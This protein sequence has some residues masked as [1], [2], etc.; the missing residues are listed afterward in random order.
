MR[1]RIS[2]RLVISTFV[3]GLA[4]AIAMPASAQTT[5]GTGQADTP[6]GDQP[7]E[8]SSGG[9]M[10]EIIV[11]AQKRRESSQKVGIAITAVSGEQIKTMGVADSV[12]IARLSSNVS[13][14][15]SYAGQ[16][17][18][19]T[20][21]GITQNDFNDHVESVIAVY[22]DDTYVA[23]QQGQ[24]FGLFDI[25]RVE[26]LKGPQGT[27][28]GRNATGGLVHYITRRPTDDFNGYAD[29]SYGSYNDVRL[30]GALG[31]RIAQG[32]R[33]RLS[34]MFERFDGYIK[35]HYPEETFV[36]IALQ[37]AL[38]SSKLPGAGADLGGMKSNW[39]LRG[40]LEF[41]LGPDTQLWMAGFGSHSVASTG[42]Y[43]Q[44]PTVAVLDAA[45]NHVNTLHA[46][47]TEVCQVIQVGACVHGGFSSYPGALRPRPGG[48]W[49]G[50]IDPDG[51]GPITSSDYTFDNANTMTTYG[52]S[53]KL[54]SSV[55]SV[56][57][58]LI[59]DYKEFKKNF[60]LDLEAGP[61]N[62]F[63]W[64]GIANTKAFTQELRVDGTSGPLKWVTGLYYLNIKTHA[65]HGI[66]A[67]PDS[68]YPIPSWDQPRIANLKTESYSAFGQLDYQLTDTVNVI[69]GLRWTREKKRYDFEV[70]FVYPND[71]GDPYGWDYSPA[72]DFPGFSQGLYA[73][74]RSETLWS[75]KGGINWQP[76]RD[77]LVYASVT[78][79]AKAGSYNAGGPPLAASEIPYKPERLISYEVG[80][81]STLFGGKARFNAA[82]YYYDYHN[83]QA[84]RWLG[85]SSLITNADATIYGGE[86]ELAASLTHNLEASFNIG[87]QHNTVKDVLV[88]GVRRNVETTF[89]PKLTLS[90]TIRYTVPT[91]IAGGEV[92]IQASA[93]YQSRVWHNL[94]NFDANS[95][96]PYGLV[97]ARID[98]TSADKNWLVAFSVKNL[99][100]N[101]YD[102]IG[103]DLSQVCG[104]NLQAQGKPRWFSVSVRRSF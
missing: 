45:G 96:A 24:T 43:Q 19:F 75:W 55:G 26:A 61:E 63:A 40:Q 94:N 71:N 80:L 54:T 41:D 60:N 102:N 30:E 39:A 76:N 100:N 29:V 42:P 57:V 85:F 25:D 70:L 51:S 87:A 1:S 90:G 82:G 23:S 18:Q 37:P 53:A 17:S 3:S 97:N 74:S 5:G 62:Q 36:P 20:I 4:L 2:K 59:S 49:F 101:V 15:G 12:D 14:S 21:R 7:S 22:I 66:A 38:H 50:Y 72:I 27:L 92:G 88:G 78:Q 8:A 13:V 104:C 52:G 93:N 98:W 73:N 91:L 56:N 58:N 64:H 32:V 34:G 67:L 28:F 68:A 10:S 44:V 16:M 47:P 31:G 48:D 33:G 84:A 65:V 11:T 81:K 89:T 103:F 35:N 9:L 69:G 77:V 79:G 83:Y 86:A 99:T 95:L 46:S 6:E